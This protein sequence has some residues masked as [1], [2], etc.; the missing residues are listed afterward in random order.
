MTQMKRHLENISTTKMGSVFSVE[1]RLT[2]RLRRSDD[3]E[4]PIVVDLSR[5]WNKKEVDKL[6]EALPCSSN[7]KELM[8]MQ[9]KI[10]GI[11]S[12]KKIIGWLHKEQAKND[13]Y[14][15]SQCGGDIRG[16]CCTKETC[17]PIYEGEE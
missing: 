16:I 9:N 5:G 10:A 7:D 11:F 15:C 6:I 14:A 4:K 17:V 13:D 1:T 3:M 8:K 2:E 12:K